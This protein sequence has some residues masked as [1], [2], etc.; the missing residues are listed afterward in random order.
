MTPT[1]SQNESV[2]PS[3]IELKKESRKKNHGPK[4]GQLANHCKQATDF[5]LCLL[6]KDNNDILPE[7]IAYCYHAL[8]LWHLVVAVDP[9]SKSWPSPILRHFQTI[10]PDVKIV[11]WQDE[12]FFLQGNYSRLPNFIGPAN[13]MHSDW[14]STKSQLHNKMVAQELLTSDVFHA[15]VKQNGTRVSVIRPSLAR[16]RPIMN[17]LVPFFLLF[18][19][20]QM[21]RK[22]QTTVRGLI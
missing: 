9:S 2:V 3:Q 20:V 8:Q 14:N 12:G 4:A 7:W 13:T 5:G 18:A 19:F 17:I 22:L 10:L 1:G 16:N 11:E 6:I 21:V 15:K